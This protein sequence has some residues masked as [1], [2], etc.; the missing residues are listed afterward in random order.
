MQE[1][2]GD[3]IGKMGTLWNNQ[4]RMLETENTIVETKTAVN[5]QYIVYNWEG[6]SEF[7]DLLT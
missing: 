7:E 6:I 5:G 1:L 3:V 4:T 2:L